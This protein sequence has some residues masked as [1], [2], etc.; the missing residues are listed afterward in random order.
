MRVTLYKFGLEEFLNDLPENSRF[1]QFT[2]L[3]QKKK[4]KSEANRNWTSAG[5]KL[6]EMITDNGHC[7]ARAFTT[8]IFE[9]TNQ[10]APCAVFQVTLPLSIYLFMNY[11]LSNTNLISDHT[12]RK[13]CALQL[14]TREQR[15]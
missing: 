5:W 12:W 10:T 9:P 11:A 8:T 2:K 14:Q 6:D 3:M 7:I 1:L 15:G 4:I 13:R